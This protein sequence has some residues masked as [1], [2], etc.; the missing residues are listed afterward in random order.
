ME[1]KNFWRGGLG[2]IRKLNPSTYECLEIKLNQNFPLAVVTLCNFPCN[3]C[4]NV[5]EDNPLHVAADMLRSAIL[6]CN[7]Q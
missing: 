3:L 6:H 4:C 7:S 1:G 5:R 2:L